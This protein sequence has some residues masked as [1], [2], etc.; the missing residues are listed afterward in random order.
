MLQVFE[1][2]HDYRIHAEIPEQTTHC[3]YCNHHKIVGFGRRNEVIIDTPF[4]GKRTKIILS[5]RRYRCKSCCKTFLDS[6]PKK[7]SKRKMTNRLI[8][9]IERE[10]LIRTFSSIANDVGVSEK[11]IRNIFKDYCE[12]LEKSILRKIH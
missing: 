9:F 7:D 10:S 5:R 12:K 8:Q 2:E 1:L 3:S 4:Q 6:V 11:T